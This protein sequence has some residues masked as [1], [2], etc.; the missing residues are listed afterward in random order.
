MADFRCDALVVFGVTGD[1][2]HKKILPVLY[3]LV[4][5]GKLEVP[6]VGVA[7]RDWSD[8][9]LIERARDAVREHEADVESAAL[10]GLERLLHYVS[11]DYS[12]PETFDRLATTLK[13][14]RHPLFYL[15]IP[16]SMFEATA[17]GLEAAGIAGGAC[18]VAIGCA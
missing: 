14:R 7:R 13:G 3:A 2:A 18:S 11:G 12:D 16:P 8:A 1:L 15:A 6:V 10:A 9:Q 17:K 4:K 5:R